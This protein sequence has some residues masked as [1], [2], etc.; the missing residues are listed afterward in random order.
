MTAMP[1]PTLSGYTAESVT[2]LRAALTQAK[3]LAD[4]FV[5]ADMGTNDYIQL[6]Q[7]RRTLRKA[8]YGLETVSQD[9]IAVKVSVLDSFDTAF[10]RT[11]EF[12]TIH[13]KNTYTAP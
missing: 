3:K 6:G 13:N 8:A 2:A 5:I 12:A 1:T 9:K 11:G 10:Q 4:E 7:A